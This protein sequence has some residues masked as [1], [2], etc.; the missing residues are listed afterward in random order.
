MIYDIQVLKG[1]GYDVLKKLGHLLDNREDQAGGLNKEEV[2]ELLKIVNDS[3]IDKV[4]RKGFEKG[5][6][7]VLCQ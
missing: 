7:E 4:Y 5:M 6:H 1:S 3:N 2:Y